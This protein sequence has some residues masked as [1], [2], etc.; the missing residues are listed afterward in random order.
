MKIPILNNESDVITYYIGQYY[1]KVQEDPSIR[2]DPDKHIYLINEINL[3][4]LKA[5]RYIPPGT[6][7]EPMDY[8]GYKGAFLENIDFLTGVFTKKREQ[9]RLAEEQEEFKKRLKTK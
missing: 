3:K 5:L 8:E 7:K 6:D 4:Y 1:D 9:A 2:I